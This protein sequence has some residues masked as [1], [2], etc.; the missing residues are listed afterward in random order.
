M[1][2]APA[3][4]WY[5]LC[6]ATLIMST[7]DAAVFGLLACCGAGLRGFRLAE[8]ADLGGAF[9]ALAWLSATVAP[10]VAW[11]FVGL[12]V[13]VGAVALWTW[14][15]FRPAPRAGESVLAAVLTIEVFTLAPVVLLFLGP[16]VLW[17]IIWLETGFGTCVPPACEAVPAVP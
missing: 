6:R 12:T 3:T 14:G 4:E 2:Q 8:P 17:P 1:V 11:F 15:W 10:A 13:L 16:F 7:T 5:S 9:T